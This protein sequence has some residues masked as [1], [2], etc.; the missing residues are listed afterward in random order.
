[1]CNEEAS[2]TPEVESGLR[3]LSEAYTITAAATRITCWPTPTSNPM[4]VLEAKT[5]PMGRRIKARQ[6]EYSEDE[7]DSGQRHCAGS[8]GSTPQDRSASREQPDRGDAGEYS[9]TGDVVAQA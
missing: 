1:M 7:I 4:K 9:A 6:P 3:L 8:S 2:D 5:Q